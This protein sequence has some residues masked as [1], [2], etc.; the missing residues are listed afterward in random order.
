M[1]RLRN[2]AMRDYQVWLPDTDRHTDRQMPDKV[3][4]IWR[5]ASQATQKNTTKLSQ[6]LLTSN[7]KPISK[8]Y[9]HLCKKQHC[10]LLLFTEVEVS[11]L[12]WTCPTLNKTPQSEHCYLQ[13]NPRSTPK[14]PPACGFIE[15][16]LSL[17]GFTDGNLWLDYSDYGDYGRLTGLKSL[18]LLNQPKLTAIATSAKTA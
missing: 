7:F 11:F 14:R 12:N 16:L 3:I 2:I 1:R 15:H 8:F 10:Y 4:T 6:T 18:R 5:Y 9:I 13:L 17:V